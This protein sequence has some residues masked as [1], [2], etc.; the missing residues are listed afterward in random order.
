MS[1]QRR[2]KSVRLAD[3][4][5]CEMHLKERLRQADMEERKR[6]NPNRGTRISK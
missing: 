3:E 4:D 5:A 1:I 2:D 6:K